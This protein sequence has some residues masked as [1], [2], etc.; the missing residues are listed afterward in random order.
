MTPFERMQAETE[1]QVDAMPR[2]EPTD[3]D[4]L[5]SLCGWLLANSS[6]SHVRAEAR[7][8]MPPHSMARIF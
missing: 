6:E 2:H 1:A 5:R 8:F 7:S 4:A 3:R